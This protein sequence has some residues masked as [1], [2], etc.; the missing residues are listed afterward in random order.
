MAGANWRGSI[1]DAAHQLEANSSH[2]PRPEGVN[3]ITTSASALPSTS[4]LGPT[5]VAAPS[6]VRLEGHGARVG[7]ASAVQVHAQCRCR[8]FH[9][10]K[11]EFS[12]P[13]CR[14]PHRRC[15]NWMLVGP[16]P[17]EAQTS[18]IKKYFGP[19]RSAQAPQP[20]PSTRR[21]VKKITHMCG[22]SERR[23][24]REDEG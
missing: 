14:R 13:S 4:T 23:E 19:L 22:F 8:H 10:F 1:I 5:C 6:V 15:R 2:L 11:F 12:I 24:L 16:G 20:P 18:F 21:L 17:S 7:A 3:R 9:I